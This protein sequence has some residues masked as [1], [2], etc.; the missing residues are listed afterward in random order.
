MKSKYDLDTYKRLAEAADFY[1]GESFK[2]IE[3]ILTEDLKKIILEEQIN[4]LSFSEREIEI[5]EEAA[6][7]KNVI[8]HLRNGKK[9]E[10][11]L[12]VETLNKILNCHIK[13]NNTI[14][15]DKPK[16]PKKQIIR[17]I[18][19]LGH[20]SNFALFVEVLT[21]RHLLFLNHTNKID[22]FIYNQLSEGNILNIII[23]IC[24][25]ELE[26]GS[27]KL[28][29]I[30]NLFKH[31]NKAVHHTPKNALEFKVK[32]EDLFQIWNQII[33]LTAIYEEKEQFIE[34]KLSSK[35]KLEKEI[36]LDTYVFY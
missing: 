35:L 24:R 32:V 25:D 26:N 13:T 33:K 8:A 18:K 5:L 11:S 9:L 6:I 10:P 23:F 12:S 2:Y 34:N 15:L 4:N 16:I 17:S 7:P 36:I 22:N 21:N 29:S 30:K 20:I 31:R 27:I 14:S 1:F 28:D 3:E 19:I